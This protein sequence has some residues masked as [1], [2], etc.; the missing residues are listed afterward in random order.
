MNRRHFIYQS[1]AGISA[2]LT[3]P[4]SAI[5]PIARKGPPRF[6]LGLAAYS[7]RD[8]FKDPAQMDLLKF[9]QFC[10]QHGVDGA[11]L[12]SYYFPK[13]PSAEFL[14]S[15][16]QQAFL[17]GVAISGTS[18]GNNFA[19]ADGPERD[20]ELAY[21]K[22]WIDYA[23]IMGAPHIRVFA[24][25]AKGISAEEG[26]K[27]VIKG[28]EEM[29]AYAGSKGVFLGLENHGGVVATA[30]GM[31]DIIKAVKSPWFGVNLDTGNFHSDD[32]YAELAACAPYAVNVQVKVEMK[33]GKNPV[34][35]ADLTKLVK[36]LRDANYQGFVT[37]EYEAKGDPFKD[38]PVWLDRL[39]QAL[40]AG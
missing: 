8:Q 12:T 31:L 3:N 16:K 27:Q 18:V 13:E 37:L 36:I 25:S 15:L 26:R 1:A 34:E 38:V 19:L 5:E 35:P 17:S 39:R 11:E 33:R 40:Q 7:F 32:P 4:L 28:F 29:C 20:K 14:L 23:S 21:V 2:A 10:A 9:L 24:G 22:Q 6:K 30:E